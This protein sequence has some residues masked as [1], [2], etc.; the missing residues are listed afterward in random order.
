MEE[1]KET[2]LAFSQGPIKMLQMRYTNFICY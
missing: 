1:V 2:I